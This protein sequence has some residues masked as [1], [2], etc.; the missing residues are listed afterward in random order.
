ML[1]NKEAFHTVTSAPAYLPTGKTFHHAAA[2]SK[3]TM[4]LVTELESLYVWIPVRSKPAARY[5]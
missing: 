4:R 5:C 1:A 2:A 3:R